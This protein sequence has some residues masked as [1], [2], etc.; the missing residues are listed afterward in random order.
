M[1]WLIRLS[2]AGLLLWAG[3]LLA[4]AAA[5]PGAW[6]VMRTG[7]AAD[8]PFGSSP[9]A[10]A[11][12]VLTGPE[13]ARLVTGFRLLEAGAAPSLLISGAGDPADY[14]DAYRPPG[15]CCYAIDHARDTLENAIFTAAWVARHQVRTLILV[16][17]DYHMQRAGWLLHRALPPGV[18]VSPLPVSSSRA[19]LPRR[20]LVEY[21]RFVVQNLLAALGLL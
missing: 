4:F 11:I 18:T 16:T 3:G 7:V 2:L 1:H 15:A 9:H 21:H 5:V 17:S 14:L 13:T 6:A 10:D 8:P 12:V 20:I 19:L